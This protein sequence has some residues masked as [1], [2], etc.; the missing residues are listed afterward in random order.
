MC[1]VINI[2]EIIN[3]KLENIDFNQIV[4][5]V[6]TENNNSLTMEAIRKNSLNGEE[7]C[8]IAEECCRSENVDL[9]DNIL[10]ENEEVLYCFYNN[11]LDIAVESCNYKLV[12][13]VLNRHSKEFSPL[14]KYEHSCHRAIENNRVDIIN[15]LKENNVT[16]PRKIKY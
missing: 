4:E 16:V 5:Y 10:K 14:L 9:L 7:I 12:Q 6:K 3:K 11:I 1:K 2:D 15:L 8:I 13:T